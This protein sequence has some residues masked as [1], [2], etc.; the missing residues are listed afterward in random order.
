MTFKKFL[1]VRRRLDP[2]L[3]A[4]GMFSVALY[5]PAAVAVAGL[6]GALGIYVALSKRR[7]LIELVRSPIG[8][9]F[10]YIAWV[11]LLLAWRGDLIPQ[12]NRQ[13]GFMGLLLGL[14]FIAPGLCLVRQPMRWLVLGAR[15][16]TFAALAASLIDQF[17]LK[18][19]P[20]R[21]D[22]GGNSAIL[23]LVVM[24][25]AIVALIPLYR[26]PRYLPNSM[27]YLVLALGPVFLSLT[28]A[29][30]VVLPAILVVE[31][32]LY[33]WR[34]PAWKRSVAFVSAIVVLFSASFLPPVAHM[35]NERFIPVYEYYVKGETDLHMESGNVR[36]ALWDTS[37]KVISEHPLIGVGIR[38]TFPE[39]ER[40]AGPEL[41][42]VEGGKHVHNF[43]LQELLANGVIGLILLLSIFAT[44]AITILRQGE[45]AALKRACFYYFG[46]IIVFGLLHDPF[47]HELCMS[48]TM[49]FLGVLIAQIGR[50]RRLTKS[51]RRL[52]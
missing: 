44:V 1:L 7:R 40:V 20:D 5:L 38:N 34:L 32:I 46:S 21:Y 43:L 36:L 2:W 15:V 28:R 10:A 25:A 3:L 50:W 51:A 24:L 52:I 47:Y 48:A 26:S 9:V 35:L 31:F 27:L 29:I 18:P 11:V 49:L 17:V 8:F 13:L 41:T 6:F 22:G 45:N 42:R 12:D 4:F 30:M 37:L 14:C 16:G 39:L 33:V 23:A 19:A